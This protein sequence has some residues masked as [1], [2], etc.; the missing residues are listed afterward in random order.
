L[1]V[2]KLLEHFDLYNNQRRHVPR[3]KLYWAI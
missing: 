1:L 2:F 3:A